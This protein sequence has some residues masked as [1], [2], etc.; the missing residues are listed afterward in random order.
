MR[1]AIEDYRG[2]MLWL[3]I[4]YMKSGSKELYC[5]HYWI[6][7][8]IEQDVK[9]LAHELAL[10]HKV[11]PFKNVKARTNTEINFDKVILLTAR[12][13]LLS[14]RDPVGNLRIIKKLDRK[15]RNLSTKE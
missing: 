7:K 13:N 8:A 12:R 4:Y 2:A 9:K 10:L 15:I 14:D 6:E 11:E 3:T 1:A 5:A